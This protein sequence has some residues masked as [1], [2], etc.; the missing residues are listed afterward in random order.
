MFLEIFGN[1]KVQ[2]RTARY[3]E[4]LGH[5]LR[6]LVAHG[7]GRLEDMVDLSLL[8]YRERDDLETA[9]KNYGRGV[10]FD[11]ETL[12]DHRLRGITLFRLYLH[13]ECM[14]FFKDTV[15]EGIKRN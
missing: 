3:I 15:E 6:S 10:P 2:D 8:R 13:I 14:R 11:V 9:F 5:E 1:C 7:T 4:Q 12:R